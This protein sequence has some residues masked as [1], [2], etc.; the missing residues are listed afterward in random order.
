MTAIPTGAAM[1]RALY[2]LPGREGSTVDHA[3]Y[4]LSAGAYTWVDARR[5]RQYD[6]MIGSAIMS[7]ICAAVTLALEY[8]DLARRMMVELGQ[9]RAATVAMDLGRE[10]GRQASSE[11]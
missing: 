5:R 10:V 7:A 2:M 3:F 11:L 8:P 4:C 9:E 6:E 1:A